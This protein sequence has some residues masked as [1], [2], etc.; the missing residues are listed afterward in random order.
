MEVDEF[1]NPDFFKKV[2]D[3]KDYVSFAAK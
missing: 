3:T 2:T 1:T